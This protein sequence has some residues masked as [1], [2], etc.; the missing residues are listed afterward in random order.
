[1]DSTAEIK[2]NLISKIKNSKDLNFLKALQTLFDESE[3]KLY[4]LSPE[5]HDAII[6]GR[7]QIKNGKFSSH[8]SVISDLREWLSKQ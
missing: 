1:M 3:Q 4:Q 8:E 5:Q 6:K 7:K 2:N